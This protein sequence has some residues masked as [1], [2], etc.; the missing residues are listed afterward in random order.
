[1]Y[2]L[3]DGYAAKE[4]RVDYTL[5]GWRSHTGQDGNS[6]SGVAKF[7]G[8][9]MYQ[10]SSY[11]L[12]SDSP[13]KNAGSDGKDVGANVALVGPQQGGDIVLQQSPP[14]PPTSVSVTVNQ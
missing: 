1:M 5:S 3:S 13:G 9:D 4:N 7:V 8:S 14:M 2:G 12:A 11:A 6:F 10:I